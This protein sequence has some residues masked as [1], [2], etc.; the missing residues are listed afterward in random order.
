MN[1]GSESMTVA[2][3]ICDINTKKMTETGARHEG[4]KVMLMAIERA[5]HGRTDRPAQISHSCKASYDKNLKTFFYYSEILTNKIL[6]YY[7][8]KLHKYNL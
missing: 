4:K 3:R 8:S 6:K 5:F 1:S 7:Y 2:M